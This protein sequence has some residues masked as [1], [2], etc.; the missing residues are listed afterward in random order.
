MRRTIAVSI[1]LLVMG[2][3]ETKV[4]APITGSA[5]PVIVVGS[6]TFYVKGA[7]YGPTWDE[8][9]DTGCGGPLFSWTQDSTRWVFT[10][11]DTTWVHGQKYAQSGC[12]LGT[13]NSGGANY[14]GGTADIVASRPSICVTVCTYAVQIIADQSS[15]GNVNHLLP[16]ATLQVCANPYMSSSF[17]FV[18]WNIRRD[19]NSVYQDYNRCLERSASVDEYEYE[20]IFKVCVWDGPAGRCDN[21]G[22]CTDPWNNSVSCEGQQFSMRL[23]APERLAVSLPNSTRQSQFPRFARREA[24]NNQMVFAY[25]DRRRFHRVG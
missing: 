5:N 8:V 13:E 18:Q 11:G 20:A 3:S 24:G 12:A 19:N 15:S 14:V 2:C 7:S 23:N 21:D 6:E 22:W 1:A 10:S 17:R 16:S 4:M 25:I 9:S